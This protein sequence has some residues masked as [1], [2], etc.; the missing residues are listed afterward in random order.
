MRIFITGAT[1][2][3]GNLL[4]KQLAANGNIVHAL[5]RNR[6]KAVYLDHYNIRIFYG[7]LN[8]NEAIQNAMDGCEFVYHVGGQV[9]P[10]L[11]ERSDYFKVNVEGTKNIC[12]EAL[13]SGV[14]KLVFT[15]STGVI[16]PAQDNPL[17]ED[18]SRMIDFSLDYDL[19]K[20]LA[21]E[22]VMTYHKKGLPSVIVSPAKVFGPGHVSHEFAGNAIIHSFI[23]KNYVLIPS[24]GSYRVCFA[25]IDDIINGHLL[26]MKK[27]VPGEKYILGGHNISYYDF[28]NSIR[29]IAGIK[30]RIISVPKSIAKLAGYLQ[31]LN[32]KIAGTPVKFT[33]KSVNHAFS[34]YI[35]SSDKAVDKLGYAITPLEKSLIT[36]ICN[37][38]N[39]H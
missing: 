35:F 1:G 18:A 2:Y 17:S 38:N 12:E 6:E 10:W 3:I 31:E 36:T 37:L 32:Y 8:N 19:S 16:G 23:K 13:R 20:K 26:A 15:S 33:A 21:E 9:R 39:P 14:K 5:I 28:F 34:N 25:Y 11:K 30:G 29:R 24:P 7:D 4:A 22:T 27:G